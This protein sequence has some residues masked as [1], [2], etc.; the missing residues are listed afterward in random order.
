MLRPEIFLKQTLKV[1]ALIL[2]GILRLFLRLQKIALINE[3]KR[4]SRKHGAIFSVNNRAVGFPF[5]RSAHWNTKIPLTHA[6]VRFYNPSYVREFSGEIRLK[7]IRMAVI[8][9]PIL[10]EEKNKLTGLRIVQLLMSQK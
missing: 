8:D 7:H 1:I 2:Y 10:Y 9:C 3:M 5:H 4:I 6:D